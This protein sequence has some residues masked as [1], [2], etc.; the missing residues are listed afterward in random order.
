MIYFLKISDFSSKFQHYLQGVLISH[1]EN[2]G[3][4]YVLLCE[5]LY[6]IFKFN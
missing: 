1:L 3:G 4:I 6:L 5:N 2:L